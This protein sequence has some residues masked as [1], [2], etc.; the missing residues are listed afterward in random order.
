MTPKDFVETTEL[1]VSRL[2]GDYLFLKGYNIYPFFLGK[3]FGRKV[4]TRELYFISGIGC[5]HLDSIITWNLELHYIHG[6][7]TQW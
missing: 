2:F 4:G 5:F 6:R 3:L 7:A 1:G